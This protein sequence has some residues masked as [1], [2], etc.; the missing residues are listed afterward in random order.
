M[1]KSFDPD[2]DKKI[3]FAVFGL[4]LS[5]LNIQ[6]GIE[7]NI[8]KVEDSAKEV[9]NLIKDLSLKELIKVYNNNLLLLGK[10]NK[11]SNDNPKLIEINKLNNLFTSP[12]LVRLINLK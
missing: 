7:T 6:N 3:L 9:Y 2:F 12:E 10:I 4:R 8:Q 11:I 1:N 5:I